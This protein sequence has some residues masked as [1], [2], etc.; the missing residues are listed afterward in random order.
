MAASWAICSVWWPM[1][2]GLAHS[3]AC[4]GSRFCGL[5]YQL[6]NLRAAKL[7]VPVCACTYVC[8]R[9]CSCACVW[10]GL[11]KLS[12]DKRVSDLRLEFSACVSLHSSL[13]EARP[14][15]TV[16]GFFQSVF[17]LQP[18]GFHLWSSISKALTGQWHIF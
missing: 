2:L 11:P 17:L 8:A 6:W 13:R 16:L 12:R 15:P 7:R 9:T 10:F 14:E 4:L 1:K 5:C 18:L 3:V